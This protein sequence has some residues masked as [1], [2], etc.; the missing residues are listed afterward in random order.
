MSEPTD[1]LPQSSEPADS[2]PQTKDATTQQAQKITIYKPSKGKC[3]LEIK[4]EKYDFSNPV[5][6]AEKELRQIK[7]R[8]EKLLNYVSARLSMFFKIDFG[9]SLQNLQTMQYGKFVSSLSNPTH[10]TLLN[11]APLKGVGILDINTRLAISMVNRILGGKLENINEER[12]LTEIE[13]SLINDIVSIIMDEWIKQFPEYQ[14]L[15]THIIGHENNPR[16]LQTAS[17]NTIMIVLSAQATFGECIQSI[18]LALPHSTLEPIVKKIQETNKQY[19]ITNTEEKNTQ[20]IPAYDHIKLP[21]FAEWDISSVQLK[22]ILSLRP[23]DILEM[24]HNSVTQTVLRLKNRRQFIGEIGL[25]KEKIAFKVN[26]KI[27]N[28]N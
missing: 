8:Y 15:E 5:C 6:L 2:L 13:I 11:I 1:S 16:F 14:N 10:T 26:Q 21:L 22:D 9:L 23:G 12:Y 19:A 3:E 18:Q 7:M 17:S 28:N 25:E 4:V 27:T 24:P 20:W